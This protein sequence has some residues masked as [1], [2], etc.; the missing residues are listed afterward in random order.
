L[1]QQALAHLDAAI[2]ADERALA[3]L[4][5]QRTLEWGSDAW[6]AM[7]KLRASLE[8]Q[9]ERAYANY[10]R[11]WWSLPESERY[12]VS[13]GAGREKVSPGLASG[14]PDSTTG[15]ARAVRRDVDD[16]EPRRW[17]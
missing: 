8:A 17:F 11:I 4:E 9:H 14:I 7:E 16:F 10:E 13:D 12:A 3:V 5:H 6:R 15:P 1:R 2:D